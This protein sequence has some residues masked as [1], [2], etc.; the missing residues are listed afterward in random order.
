MAKSRLAKILPLAPDVIGVV[1]T[2]A[3]AGVSMQVNARI[4][5]EILSRLDP[6]NRLGDMGGQVA[7]ALIA[8]V[9]GG[10]VAQ[11]TRQ[12]ALGVAWAIGPVANAVS[13]FAANVIGGTGVSGLHS[14]V[15]MPSLSP[16][17]LPSGVRLPY[18]GSE[19]ALSR[20]RAAGAGM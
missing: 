12:K 8:L 14:T 11:F 15:G 18:S 4:T 3:V 19:A 5:E 9:S 17:G 16:D 2:A 20:I 1:K 10:L 7:A 13:G 6:R